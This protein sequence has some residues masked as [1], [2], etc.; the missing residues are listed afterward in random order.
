MSV[1]QWL[2]RN[3]YTRGAR[4]VMEIVARSLYTSESHEV[5]M[6]CLL[7]YVASAGS[8]ETQVETRGDGAQRFK[9][10]GGAFQL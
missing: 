2:R 8:L 10:H 7:S 6:L 5:S 3:L 4:S 9:V 1:D